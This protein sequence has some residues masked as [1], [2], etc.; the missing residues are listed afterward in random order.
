MGS[1]RRRIAEAQVKL[2]KRQRQKE[3]KEIEQL[4]KQRNKNLRKANQYLSKAKAKEDAKDAALKR[5]QAKARL[6]ATKNQRGKALLA[7]VSSGG[8]SL[9][10]D[11]RGAIEG[12]PA[13][14][15]KRTTKNPRRG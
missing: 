11:L 3:E 2:R 1:L 15:K 13:R 10:K 8:K 7:Q 6:N 14:R 12:K 4:Q 9:M 5:S